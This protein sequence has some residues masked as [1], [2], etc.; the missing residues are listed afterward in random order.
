LTNLNGSAYFKIPKDQWFP[1]VLGDFESSMH[2][3][4]G[5]SDELGKHI[6]NYVREEN[7]NIVNPRIMLSSEPSDRQILINESCQDPHGVP[8]PQDP[9]DSKCVAYVNTKAYMQC[10]QSGFANIKK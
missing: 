1:I 3:V 6:T 8:T 4:D 9:G 2:T 5:G 7:N 10:L